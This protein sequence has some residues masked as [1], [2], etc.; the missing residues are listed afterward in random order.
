LSPK[1]SAPTGRNKKAQ[2][3]ALGKCIACAK[4]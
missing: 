4:P 1:S 2:G 3:Y